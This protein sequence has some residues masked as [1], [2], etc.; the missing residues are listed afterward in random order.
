MDCIEVKTAQ[1]TDTQ[2][3]KITS[4]KWLNDPSQ[5]KK[6]KKGRQAFT[7]QIDNNLMHPVALE[8]HYQEIF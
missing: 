6:K 7:S 1:K 5:K 4:I 3:Y 2:E 8:G